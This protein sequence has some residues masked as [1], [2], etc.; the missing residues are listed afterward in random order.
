MVLDTEGPDYFDQSMN[1]GNNKDS[2]MIDGEAFGQNRSMS[3]SPVKMSIDL[4]KILKQREIEQKGKR[5]YVVSKS[6][7]PPRKKSVDL[8]K[9]KSSTIKGS[10]KEVANLSNVAKMIGMQGNDKS[11]DK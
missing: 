11:T 10:P 5:L 9:K 6:R 2:S 1:V 7:S 8:L 4:S 3:Q